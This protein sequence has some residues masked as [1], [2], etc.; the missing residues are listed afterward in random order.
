MRSRKR[1]PKAPDTDHC[2]DRADVT[3]LDGPEPD[4]GA[5]TLIPETDAQDEVAQAEARAEAARARLL[6]LRQAADIPDAGD[7]VEPRLG[8]RTRTRLRR[9]RRPRRP[10]WLRRPGRKAVA[11]SASIVLVSAS[12]GASGYM[13]WQHRKIMHNRQLVAE[14][15]AAARQRVTTLMSIDANHAKE[16]FQRIL[17][18]S[19]GD[20]KKQ[21]S[22]MAGLMAKQAEDSKVS[23]T[24]TVQAVAVQSVSDN[25]G[26]VLVAAKS[27]ATGPDN[28]KLPTALWRISVSLTRDDG[29]LKMSKVDFLQ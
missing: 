18:A 23:S 28:A 19:T 21:M 2:D 9:L 26:V 20:L 25:S 1:S 10:R 11:V 14:Y 22:V 17:D 29:Q 15:S 4:S 7:D 13:V 12:L 5:E 27:D 16:G 8:E 6:R 3:D 24:V